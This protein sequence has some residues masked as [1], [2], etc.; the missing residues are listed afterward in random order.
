VFLNPGR[1][2]L[3]YAEHLS[4]LSDTL[5]ANST[6][7]GETGI[8]QLSNNFLPQTYCERIIQ[9]AEV[10]LGRPWHNRCLTAWALN[11][12]PVGEEV[13]NRIL[14]SLPETFASRPA[15]V[16]A[17]VY[18][19]DSG[20]RIEPHYDGKAGDT[21][22]A[23]VIYLNADL[24]QTQEPGTLRIVAQGEAGFT[25]H[26]YRPAG[27]GDGI[28]FMTTQLDRFVVKT[29]HPHYSDHFFPHPNA[30]NQRRWVLGI[31]VQDPSLF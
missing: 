12:L 22:L 6:S 17:E 3:A 10:A 29:I 7:V 27:T 14:A 18:A 11:S 23:A 13:L 28:A 1:A 5:S 21:M 25:E 15:C 2:C 20:G 24:S 9:E 4:Q 8:F 26:S 19:M 31:A 30:P 16:R